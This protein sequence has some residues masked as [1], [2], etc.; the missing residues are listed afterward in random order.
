M[1]V[2]NEAQRSFAVEQ[3]KRQPQS[4]ALDRDGGDAIPVMRMGM[5][6]KTMWMTIRMK[7]NKFMRRQKLVVD[8]GF[9]GDDCDDYIYGWTELDW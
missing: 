7:T 6:L 1:Q 4:D 9:D 3:A 8:A 5:H 2:I